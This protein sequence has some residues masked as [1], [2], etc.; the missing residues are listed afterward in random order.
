MPE[1][2]DIGEIVARRDLRATAP[3]GSSFPVSLQVG[4]PRPDPTPG[5]DW[6]CPCRVEGLDGS[7][8]S[9]IHGVDGLQALAL[10]VDT[11]R[12]RLRHLAE[13]GNLTFVW[14]DEAGLSAAE[15][16]L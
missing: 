13:A 3:D 5:G 14:G 12:I 16:S 2:Q 8:V 4:T 7:S 15:V 6:V 9:E 10:A 11:V 1:A